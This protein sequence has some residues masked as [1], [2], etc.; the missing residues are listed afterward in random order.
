MEDFL[1]NI[2]ERSGLKGIFDSTQNRIFQS[3]G[4][5]SFLATVED[6]V[7][8]FLMNWLPSQLIP[9]EVTSVADNIV[10]TIDGSTIENQINTGNSDIDQLIKRSITTGAKD[11][12]QGWSA[13]VE[14]YLG[15][16]IDSIGVAA[17][18][19]RKVETSITNYYTELGINPNDS[20][21]KVYAAAEAERISGVKAN[22]N[23]EFIDAGN[24]GM[25]DQFKAF[26]T[27]KTNSAYSF[28]TNTASG[29]FTNLEQA[30][31]AS[32][33]AI[34]KLDTHGITKS[35]TG[36]DDNQF[37]VLIDLVKKGTG[38][39]GPNPQDSLTD[40]ELTT[41]Q[42]ALPADAIKNLMAQI[43]DP[44]KI[45]DIG[46]FNAAGVTAIAADVQGSSIPIMVN[47]APNTGTT[48]THTIN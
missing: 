19:Y 5:T 32:K 47:F 48:V 12:M 23:G 34:Q 21:L 45:T 24:G 46:F 43:S 44:S 8:H 26:I 10:R 13:V 42:S 41:I 16:G 6:Y 3:S 29:A 25:E 30:S 4:W 38:Q 9:S 40:A 17:D 7:T 2:Y 36:V 14:H 27:K 35:A 11:T 31:A 33:A 20:D 39:T 22:S 18:V 15:D 28:A 37:S 1:R